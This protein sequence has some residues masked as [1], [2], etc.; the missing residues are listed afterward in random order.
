MVDYPAAIGMF[1]DE[2]RTFIDACPHDA[3][4]IHGTGTGNGQPSAQDIATFFQN[5]PNEASSHYVVGRDGG[6]VQVVWE[7]D[8]SGA[9]CC[10]E[11]GYD[12][13]WTPYLNQYGNLNRC[14]L[15]IEHVHW[16]SDNSDGLT[17][18]Q[19]DASFKLVAYLV[20]KYN[21]PLTHIKGHNSIDPI[22]R[23]NCPGAY[24]WTELF[25]YLQGGS[26]VPQGWHDDGQTLTAPNGVAVRL[27]FRDF[28]LANNWDAGNWALAAEQGV[29]LLEASNPALG[30][31]TQQLFRWAMLGYTQQRGVFLEWTGQELGFVR[32]Q[33]ASIYPAYKQLKAEVDSLTAQ[34]E[35]LQAQQT[36]LVPASAVKDRLTAIGLAATNGNTAVQQLV[37]Q[38]L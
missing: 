19:Q 18:A 26:M 13:F 30:G 28:V 14:T 29:Q 11:Q 23:A 37:T 15:S 32:G 36:G 7:K 38:P 10:V 17:P 8:G 34:I 33:L 22:N 21:I 6:V 2:S 4:V 5:D 35:T 1:V 27:G 16:T 20:Q 31:G 25:T 9:N 24:P 3:I 12:S